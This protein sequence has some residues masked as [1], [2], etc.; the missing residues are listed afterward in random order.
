ML[1]CFGEEKLKGRCWRGMLKL[2]WGRPTQG[3]GNISLGLEAL[4]HSIYFSVLNKMWKDT[5]SWLFTVCFTTFFLSCIHRGNIS[6][7]YN[8]LKMTA[9]LGLSVCQGT[10]MRTYGRF[11]PVFSKS[12]II[13]R[14][15]H[16]RGTKVRLIATWLLLDVHKI[17]EKNSKIKS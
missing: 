8:L 14:L 2:T 1:L 4:S 12:A 11:F 10:P 13:L 6:Q 3:N 16:S 15:N 17:R 9:G 5:G 7:L